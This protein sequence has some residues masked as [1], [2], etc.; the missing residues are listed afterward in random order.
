MPL[1]VTLELGSFDTPERF[2]WSQC[3]QLLFR[4]EYLV[5][6]G[7]HVRRY[8]FVVIDARGARVGLRLGGPQVVSR[9]T[10]LARHANM[11]NHRLYF[12]WV[13][14]EGSQ[15]VRYQHPQQEDVDGA[16]NVQIVFDK[17]CGEGFPGGWPGMNG[18]TAPRTLSD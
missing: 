12:P 10:G 14:W 16:N 11:S 5:L 8:D 4:A 6:G 17:F 3:V 9:Q 1:A 2:R 15:D 18:R 13:L 7:V